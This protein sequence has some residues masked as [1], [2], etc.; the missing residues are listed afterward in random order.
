MKIT[1]CG[2]AKIVTGS[3]FLIEANNEKILIDCGMFQGRKEVTKLNYEP[4]QFVPEEIDYLFLTHAHIDHSGLIP[5]LVK[6]GFKGQIYT[7]STTV[8]LIKALLEDSAGIQEKDIEHENRRRRRIGLPLREPLY[9]KEDVAN[10]FQFLNRVEYDKKYTVGNNLEICFRDAGHILGSASIE[11]WIQEGDKKTKF[12]F[13][14]DLGQWDVPIVRDPTIIEEADYVIVESTYGDRIHEEKNVREERLSE[15]CR[16]TFERGGKVLIPTF[17]VE[18]TQELLYAFNKLI[19]QHKFPKK[20]PIFLDSP[21]AIR[22]TD[23]FKLHKECYDKE[24]KL[25]YHNIFNFPNL[26]YSKTVQDSMRLNNYSKSCVIMA[27]SGMCTGGRIRHHFKHGIWNPKNTI[28]FVGYQADST[29][30]RFLLNGAEHVRMMGMEFAVKAQ[31]IKIDGFSAHADKNELVKWVSGFK[32]K[33]K[34]VFIVHGEPNSQITFRNNLKKI[35]F[36]CEIPSIGDSF[37]L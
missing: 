17:A 18:R 10:T 28:L 15:I 12:V 8:D 9:K 13:S 5:K 21:L 34:K 24:A 36:K 3:C 7:H 22:V 4:F 14:G 1:F 26:E 32:T 11:L 35:G 20:M 37:N 23:I 29:L 33:P 30:G 27:G 19:K 16:E 2:A 6:E 25:E 31:I